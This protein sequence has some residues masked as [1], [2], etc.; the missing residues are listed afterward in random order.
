MARIAGD[1]ARRAHSIPGGSRRRRRPPACTRERSEGRL[2]GIATDL[3]LALDPALLADQAGFT[4]DSW[5]AQVLRRA[6]PRLLL[7]CSRQSGKST[8]SAVLAVHTALYEPGAL[9]LLLS[10]SQR[11]SA[12]LF[13]KCL[14][15][16][17]ALDRPVL[18]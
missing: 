13:K 2:M 9:V 6:A 14:A 12:E 7:N 4:P 10:P 18:P 3:A 11:Q 1:A 8:V 17:R 16:Y 15:I 5:Q